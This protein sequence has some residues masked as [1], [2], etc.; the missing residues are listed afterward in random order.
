MFKLFFYLFALISLTSCSYHQR[1]SHRVISATP[2]NLPETNKK[3]FEYSQQAYGGRY[4]LDPELSTYLNDLTKKIVQNSPYPNLSCKVVIVNSSI[5]NLWSFPSGHIAITRGLL[6]ELQN[7]DELVGVLSHEISHLYHQDGRENIQKI[8]LNAGPVKL[9]VHKNYYVSDFTVGPLGSGSGLLTLKY[10]VNSE[11]HADQSAMIQMSQMGYSPKAMID[12]QQRINVYQKSK[13]PNWMGG[14]IAKHPFSEYQLNKCESCQKQYKEPSQYKTKLFSQHLSLLKSQVS[15][16]EKLD[17]GYTALLSQNYASA[18]DIAN[19]GLSEEPNESHFLLLKAKAQTRLGNFV[20]ALKALNAAIAKDPY[21]F[22]HY[23]QRGLVKEQL[24]D[25]ADACQDLERSL[26]LLPT[27]EA[28]YALG[29]IDYNKER[30]AEAIEYFRKASISASP[31]GKRALKKLKNLGLPTSGLKTIQ[32]NPIYSKTG[33]LTLEV[34]NQGTRVARSIVVDVEQV[35]PKGK[36]LFRH[37]IEIKKDLSPSESICQ[38][39]NIGPFF[40]QEH[41]QQSTSTYPVYCD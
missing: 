20:P 7:E 22:D 21:Y 34:K 18:I 19:E 11:V 1:N 12:L 9:N 29:E 2:S 30:Q 38:K 16:Y 39:T 31:G 41:L 36:L 8:I 40:S 14:Y 33:H 6:T 35:D 27:A 15:T 17:K 25:W 13:D 26:A 10:D 3:N 24:D 23:L 37:F 4:S 28:Y 32:V 5:P